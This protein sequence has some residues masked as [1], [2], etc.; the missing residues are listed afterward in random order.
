LLKKNNIAIQ[1]SIPDSLP[2]VVVDEEKIDR[3]LANLIDN[4]VKHTADDGYIAVAAELKDGQ[5][6]VS[7]TN[8]GPS[9][10]AEDRHRIFDRFTQAPGGRP[11]TRGFGLGLAFCRLAVEAHGGRIWVEAGDDGTSNRFI[12]SLPLSVQ[13]QSPKT[14]S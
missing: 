1:A 10:P 3:V 7:V 9:I 13:A 2:T 6:L 11:K 8:T 5:V 12:F 14:S 4:A